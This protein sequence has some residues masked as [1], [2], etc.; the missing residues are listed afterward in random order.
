MC[1]EAPG[2]AAP[3][4]H[5]FGGTLLFRVHG[6]FDGDCVG[7]ALE[8]EKLALRLDSSPPPTPINISSSPSSSSV[9]EPSSSGNLPTPPAGDTDSEVSEEEEDSNSHQAPH[10]AQCQSGLDPRPLLNNKYNVVL[11][12]PFHFT[13]STTPPSLAFQLVDFIC[14]RPGSDARRAK[15]L[16]PGWKYNSGTVSGWR[17]QYD[18]S[19]LRK[20]KISR[21]MMWGEFKRTAECLACD[22]SRAS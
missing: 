18:L 9:S 15:E 17:R 11:Q 10:P 21:R 22:K 19:M 14:G 4:D 20:V 5:S 7:L 8:M 3:K 6:V 12:L 2:K 16:L 13:I 1:V